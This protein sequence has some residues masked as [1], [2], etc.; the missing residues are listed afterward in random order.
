MAAFR[1]SSGKQLFDSIVCRTFEDVLDGSYPTLY[2]ASTSD[3]KDKMRTLLYVSAAIVSY[4]DFKNRRNTMNDQQIAET[5]MLIIE[6]FPFL[7]ITDLK[8]FIRRLKCNVYG[9]VYDLDGQAFIGWLRKYVEEKRTVQYQIIMQREREEKERRDKEAEEFA[10][11]PEGKAAQ[12]KAL[13]MFEKLRDEFA[14]KTHPHKKKD[15][16]VSSKAVKN[17]DPKQARIEAIRRNV[18]AE[19][20]KQ[21]LRNTPDKYIEVMNKLINEELKKEGLL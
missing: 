15:E 5:A 8:L 7:K 4:L 1:S 14:T 13:Q 11:T 6:E 16:S 20:D 19:N 2:E 3:E 21:V 9:E 10:K 17:P 12:E 18:I